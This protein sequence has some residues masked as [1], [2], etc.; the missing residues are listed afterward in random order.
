M[1]KNVNRKAIE[2]LRGANPFLSNPLV[3]VCGMGGGG[4]DSTII[5]ISAPEGARRLM[6]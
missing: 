6:F 4:V 1:A 3:V 2:G 5:K